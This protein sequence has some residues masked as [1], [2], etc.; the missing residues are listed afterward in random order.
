MK[1]TSG[2]RERRR[3]R[4]PHAWFGLRSLDLG[5]NFIGAEGA[6]ALAASPYFSGLTRLELDSNGIG[7]EG[8]RALAAS[9]HLA[10][11]TTLGLGSNYFPRRW[12]AGVGGLSQ[13]CELDN[14]M[15]LNYN[16]IEWKE[17]WAAFA[18]SPHLARLTTLNLYETGDMTCEV[19]EAMRARFGD[20][21]W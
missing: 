14:S 19:Y 18:T 13:F 8:V 12:S 15:D 21:Q 7:A 3:W 16:W 11:L 17:V 4:P 1:T 20:I 6:A 9:P 2:P 5:N 10:N